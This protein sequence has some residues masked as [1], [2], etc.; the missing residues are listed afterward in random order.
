MTSEA[1]RAAARERMRRKRA[2]GYAPDKAR[3]RAVKRLI[4]SYP[5][6]YKRLYQEELERL[7]NG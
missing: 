6:V 3:Q 7:G 2:Q 5:L 4:D 1:E